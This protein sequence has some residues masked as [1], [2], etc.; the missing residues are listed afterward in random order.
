MKLTLKQYFKI[1]NKA[2]K[3]YFLSVCPIFSISEQRRTQI[4]GT[5]IL[6]VSGNYRFLLTA[7]H[8]LGY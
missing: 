6:L 2:A 1:K 8:V 3:I 4:E 5:G 7:S